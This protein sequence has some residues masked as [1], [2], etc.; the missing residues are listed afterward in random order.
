MRTILAR[1][2]CA[3]VHASNPL[4]PGLCLT[5]AGPVVCAWCV[6]AGAC[7]HKLGAVDGGVLVHARGRGHTVG[8][9]AGALVD[10]CGTRRGGGD[11]QQR[12]AAGCEPARPNR[13]LLYMCATWRAMRWAPTGAQPPTQLLAS[14]PVKE[15]SEAKR[16][17]VPDS[18]AHLCS[19]SRP[20][21]SHPCKSR[22]SCQR[23]RCTRRLRRT[24]AHL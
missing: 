5:I 3:P 20:S 23:C 1:Q 16:S 14:R 13:R 24:T 10:V 17:G 18:P 19:W 6:A 2:D 22:C 15:R 4:L 8:G 7:A 12:R 11:T 21:G 9:A